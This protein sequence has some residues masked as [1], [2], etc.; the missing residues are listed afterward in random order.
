MTLAAEN[1]CF[2]YRPGRR[3]L[4]GITASFP[5]GTVTAVIGPNGAGKTTLLRLLLGLLQPVSG[6]VTLDGHDVC[7]LRAPQRAARLAYI[8][9]RPSSADG[10]SVAQVVRMGRYA[11][12]DDEGAVRRA[13]V[14]AGLEDRAGEPLAYLSAGQQQRAA[15]A[16]VLAQLD[17]R[18]GGPAPATQVILA[19]EPCAAMDPRHQ[20]EAMSILRAQASASGGNRAV[21]VAMHDLT[22]ALRFADRALVLDRSG[23]PAAAGPTEQVLVP[24][25]LGRVFG[26][27]FLVSLGDCAAVI[28]CPLEGGRADTMSP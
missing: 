19:D 5:P 6:R 8:P 22:A 4:S 7:R 11:R 26:L 14:A 24:G 1:L 18:A 2:E 17:A 15:L 13:L 9:Q 3:V 10:F 21:V 12:P 27:K 23:A 28:P 16:R 20:M 25:V